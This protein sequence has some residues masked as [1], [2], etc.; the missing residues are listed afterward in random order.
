MNER[1]SGRWWRRTGKK[2]I[3]S[4]L[5]VV[6]LI[7]GTMQGVGAVSTEPEAPVGEEWVMEEA[8]QES[9]DEKAAALAGG[10]PVLDPLPELSMENYVELSGFAEAGADIMVYYVRDG[11]EEVSIGEPVRAEEDESGVGRFNLSLELP[12]EGSYIFTAASGKDGAW[13]ERSAP[14]VIK[15][16]WTSPLDPP[17]MR[18]ELL[19]YNEV[20]I[21][22]DAAQREDGS[23]DPEIAAYAIY[24]AV[25]NERIAERTETYYRPEGLEEGRLYRYRV[26]S[27]DLAG[28]ESGGYPL[29]IGTSPSTENKLIG[30]YDRGGSGISNRTTL[31][32]DGSTAI[33]LDRTYEESMYLGLFSV[34]AETRA[35]KLLTAT[36]GGEPIDGSIGE[37]AVSH[38]GDIVVFASDATNLP[39]SPVERGE[40]VYAYDGETGGM[41]LLSRAGGEAGAP[42]IS[43][44]G[45]WVAYADGGRIYLHDRQS[46]ETRLVSRAAGGTNE[47]GS[48]SYPAIS[49]NGGIVAFV[50]D[51]TNLEGFEGVHDVQAIY[52]YDAVED[53]IVNRHAL[54]ETHA[55]LALNGDGRYIA[56]LH[57]DEW[58]S[59]MSPF[60]LDRTTGDRMALNSQRDEG[61]VTGK[62]YDRLTISDDGRTV[63]AN[64]FDYDSELQ[65]LYRFAEQFSLDDLAHPVTVGNPALESVG[66]AMNAEGDR[67]VYAR[68]GDLYMSCSGDCGTEEPDRPIASGYWS[69]SDGS[70]LQGEL[71]Q[72]SRLSIQAAGELGQRLQAVVAYRSEPAAE[73]GATET[74]TVDLTELEGA[75]GLYRGGFDVAAG[76]AELLSIEVRTE[77]GGSKLALDRLPIRIAAALTVKI[78]TDA[79]ERLNGTML[80]LA[81]PDGSV[82]ELPV[83]AGQLNEAFP[84][85]S[86][87]GYKLELIHVGSRTVLALAEHLSFRSGESAVQVLEPRYRATVA[88]K[89]EYSRMPSVQAVVRFHDESDDRLLGEATADGNGVAKLSAE[90]EAGTKVRIS[91]LPPPGF[92][93]TASRSLTLA[94]GSNEQSFA[95]QSSDT[96]VSSVRMTYAKPQNHSYFPVAIMDSDA[97][98]TVTGRDGYALQA[99]I[100]Y[101]QW[102][103]EGELREQTRTIPL[104]EKQ[105]GVYEGMFRIEDG[106][107]RIHSARIAVEGEW[108]GDRY[109]IPQNVAGRVKAKL[110]IPDGEVWQ[111]AMRDGA[112]RVYWT[113][114]ASHYYSFRTSLTPGNK[115]YLFDLPKEGIPY[116]LAL[117]PGYSKL[118]PAEIGLT[119]SVFGKTS[120]ATIKPKFRIQLSGKA[121]GAGNESVAGSYEL[122]DMAGTVLLRG[123]TTSLFDIRLDSEAGARYKLAFTPNDPLY[124]A[125]EIEVEIERPV[126]Q[127]KIELRAK[128]LE[129]IEGKVYGANGQPAGS[130]SVTAVY[131]GMS[132]TFGTYTKADGSYTLQ[133]PPGTAKIRA[134][135]N[136]RSG[137][138]SRLETVQI[139][140]EGKQTLDLRLHELARVRFNLYT[141]QY[142]SDW[143]GPLEPD[144]RLASVFSFKPSHAISEY[145]APMK[146]FA[147][148]GDTYRLCV[149]GGSA[150]LPA[151]CAEAV[152]GENNEAVLELRLEGSG[153]QATATFVKPDGTDAGGVR[154]ELVRLEDGKT[155]HEPYTIRQQGRQY[156]AELSKRGQYRLQAT[157][158]G[159]LAAVVEFSADSAGI[160]DLGE[161]VLRKPIRFGG[162]S[163]NGLGVSADTL[164][165]GGKL[166]VRALYRNAGAPAAGVT[167]ASV[168]IH[169]PEG[170]TLLPGSVVVNGKAAEAAIADG[171]L[172][173]SIGD[174]AAGAQGIVQ[175]GLQAD[176]RELPP[177]LF[178]SGSI[179]YHDGGESKEETLGSA[180]VNIAAVTLRMP[181]ILFK[182]EFR[183]SGTA[184][185]GTTVYVYE[186]RKLLGTAAVSSQGTW[187]L[188]TA[189]SRTDIRQ[190]LIRT[191]AIADGKVYGGQEAVATYDPNDPGLYE[192]EVGQT[193]GRVHT[194]HPENGVAVFP[195]VYVP[196]QPFVYKL[197]FRDP[198]RVSNVKVWTGD[199]AADAVLRNGEYLAT[200]KLEGD[201]GPIHVTYDAKA[202]VA[203]GAG[204]P[205]SEEE[206]RTTLPSPLRDYEVEHAA[207]PGELG[208][209]GRPVPADTV[210]ALVRMTKELG[211]RVTIQSKDS[212]DYAPTDRD[213]Q[214]AARTGIPMYGSAVSISRGSQSATLTISGHIAGGGAASRGFGSLAFGAK[215]FK[216][217]VDALNMGTKIV[218][219]DS[220]LQTAASPQQADRL[221]EL[222]QRAQE[223]CDPKAAEY[224]T[225]MAEGIMFDA[226]FVEYVKNALNAVGNIKLSG[227]G[228]FLF[229]VE[230]YWAGKQLDSV[231]DDQIAEL[232]KYLKMNEC[233]KKPQKPKTP[234]KASPKYIYDPSGYVYEGLE[235]N[236]LEG[237]TATVMELDGASG[238][239]NV[240]DAEWYEQQNPQTTDKAGRYGW[241][242]PPGWW[243]VKYE[244]EG[245]ETAHSANLE[246]PP[247]HFDVN[248]G[249]VSH[250]A[251]VVAELRAQPG[252]RAIVA[253]FSKPVKVSSITE[254]AIRVIRSDGEPVPGT[255]VAVEPAA[256]SGG[257]MLAMSAAFRP[258]AALAAGE[259]YTVE[260]GGLLTSYAGSA[261]EPYGPESVSI[262]AADTIPP[263]PV[264]GLFGSLSEDS[265]TLAWS[266]PADYDL[267]KLLL[268]WREA[269]EAA[270]GEPVEI[271]KGLEWAYVEGLSEERNYD[272][273]VIAVD[274]HGN[275][276]A[277]ATWTLEAAVGGPDWSAPSAVTGFKAAEIG[278]DAI[279]LVW[280]DPAAP[281]LAKVKV[282]WGPAS[283]DAAGRTVEVGTGI[284]KLAMKGLQPNTAY[285]FEAIAVDHGGNESFAAVLEATTSAETGGPGHGGD[286]QPPAKPDSGTREWT[287]DA[288]GGSFEAF[289]GA[290]R[291]DIPQGAASERSWRI[292]LD[293]TADIDEAVPGGYVR[294]SPTYL[295]D[296]GVV[297]QRPVKLTIAYV[298]EGFGYD[299]RRFGLYRKTADEAGWTYVGG[300]V[301]VAESY[302]EADIDRLGEYAV[303]MRDRSFGD[304][305]GHWARTDVEVLASRGVVDGAGDGQFR[306]ERAITRAELAKLLVELHRQRS[307]GNEDADEK[308]SSPRFSDVP[309]DAWYAPYLAEAARY[310]LLQGSNGMARP[311]ETIT[312][313]ELA[314]M[315][316]RFALFSGMRPEG[317]NGG[318]DVLAGY[319]DT[320]AVS[321]WAQEGMRQAVRRGWLKGVTAAELKPRSG[322]SRAQA[323]VMLHR[324]L[325]DLGWISKQE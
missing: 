169:V 19:A 49:G 113:N 73:A 2:A 190:V 228:G 297:L 266:D 141:K 35:R 214:Q 165:Q 216:M 69:V 262:V 206:A 114:D 317:S 286:G 81:G 105:R 140:G 174:A 253:A 103:D 1:R 177:S 230:G 68:E 236:R 43:N 101:E 130:S 284:G 188:D 131:E 235:S 98:L 267:G 146:V 154:L 250:A 276:S 249:L 28:N 303:L 37:F 255:V 112:L 120:G 178:L 71:K 293:R 85:A 244:K 26:A 67:I 283:D 309:A 82:Y 170:M 175:L 47:D 324:L 258:E 144:W 238:A 282:R 313:E 137:Y 197:K 15:L 193:G 232:E 312:R 204:E 318:Q 44:D 121:A 268:R 243:K 186:G 256:G 201:P 198:S 151:G 22:W 287:V 74:L 155:I 55:S 147:A 200:M 187:Q 161:V 171:R 52:A 202:S 50:S 65:G 88:A 20:L 308:A 72:G 99:E 126:M 149:N 223:L 203:A 290:L 302:M 143:Q 323:A 189:L 260:V 195:F 56:Y 16:D 292:R 208:A 92:L 172:R 316:S 3:L 279:S 122:K 185:A 29:T 135:G 210:S 311:N 265:A 300:A 298:G 234:P 199:T 97:T 102:D 166:T 213:L 246:V 160:V 257:E 118:K 173:V 152:I 95:L 133:L 80:A 6:L 96:V 278:K 57:G 124:H 224:Y 211:A 111:D 159:G 179:G 132:R 27:V 304:L 239:W 106:V 36:K 194:I 277:A 226:L 83:K 153:A 134:A 75:A 11:E 150:G 294:M 87:S 13:G 77:D 192:I 247:P 168:L 222:R 233:M 39:A 84:V 167:D 7:T 220:A 136:G 280:K 62:N 79:P 31:S 110:D 54:A 14:V 227:L 184:P 115:E 30:L 269:G 100:L 5:L 296:G 33:V 248:V 164:T 45:R 4:L 145:G 237:V 209:D 127:L 254:G 138:L 61:E 229:W 306:P 40:H 231:M 264:E 289:E 10:G 315:L 64:L 274:E 8:L 9:G 181:D 196:G 104:A 78:D 70:W 129:T 281:D 321:S 301:D 271:A 139:D 46:G 156:I 90:L 219:L 58:G 252:G 128:N 24:D 157:G 285:R 291:L 93:A 275:E 89:L 295:L 116:R 251:P 180:Y 259:T 163:G 117:D 59:W 212:A 261:I 183:A 63:L 320:G 142:G 32:G 25:T 305:T 307:G 42:S 107:A 270:Y 299:P 273:S 91:V 123:T 125:E 162:F 215:E 86:G 148:P 242:V 191:E 66:A 176:G 17:S 207:G 158:G 218:D 288:D 240:W 217:V 241:D 322:A 314:V 272:F 48:S 51:S 76:M 182:P 18:W 205:P 319:S 263:G 34:D 60:L 53:A 12:D 245:Y 94:I 38:G 325:Q 41:E 221:R 310:G 109:A 108:T 119:E 225:D 21:S 23:S